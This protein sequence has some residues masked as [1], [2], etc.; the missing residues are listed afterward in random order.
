M[1]KCTWQN[2]K[3]NEDMLSQIQINAVVKKI[4]S[5]GNNWVKQFRRMARDRLPRLIVKYQTF[6]KRN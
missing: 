4:Q 2:N 1:A 5:Y 3:I 6:G